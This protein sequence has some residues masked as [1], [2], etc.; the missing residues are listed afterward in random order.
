MH[1]Y[2]F[3][4]HAET[5][6]IYKY[7]YYTSASQDNFAVISFNPLMA[8]DAFRCHKWFHLLEKGQLSQEKV[9]MCEN[10]QIHR[11]DFGEKIYGFSAHPLR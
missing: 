1:G 7:A 6:G 10:H 3:Y 11:A 5:S 8:N 2:G 4:G 9:Q